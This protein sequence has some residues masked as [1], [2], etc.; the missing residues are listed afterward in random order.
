MFPSGTR[1]RLL[2]LGHRHKP[3]SRMIM[4]IGVSTGNPLQQ[5]T[6]LAV[7]FGWQGVALPEALGSLLE[8]DDW[9]G[10][11]R[12]TALLYPRGAVA[13]RRVLLVGL[14][15]ADGDVLDCIADAAAV[16]ARRAREIGVERYAMALPSAEQHDVDAVAQALTEG[17]I[18]GLYRFV[19]H[20]SIKTALEQRDIAEATIVV[21]HDEDAV[22][23]GVEAGSAIAAGTLLARDL[24]NA[25]GN[26]LPPAKLG[27]AAEELGAQYPIDVTVLGLS[28]LTAQGFGG[29]LAVGQGSANEPCFIVMEYGREHAS[30][31][32]ICLVGKGI[33]F[34]SGGISIKPAEN[35][36]R[37]KDDMSGA[38]AVLGTMRALGQRKLPIHVVGLISSAENMPSST[39]YRPGD[40]VTT[41][42]GIT[43]EVLNT[44]AE[45]RIVL[46]DALYYAQRYK[47]AAIIDLATLTGAIG[48]ALGPFASGLMSNNDDVAERLTQAGDAT[49]ERLWR[50]PLWQPYKDVVKSDFADI[51]NTGGRAGGALTAAAFLSFF[52]GEYPWAH[53]DIAATAWNEPS[54]LAKSYHARGATGVGVRLLMA[55]L[56]AWATDR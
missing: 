2:K 34:D 25:P 20:K 8:A 40:I 47:P 37:M 21:E 52:V 10:A 43:V 27:E 26:L 19:G 28:E 24:A 9:K 51:K 54:K 36:D 46:A 11:A 39:S 33:T 48:V 44:D 38:A 50:M 14:G 55:A 22:R 35:M 17:S 53:L 18:L 56:S 5:D 6:P 13:P 1:H 30:N 23:A 41:L 15:P 29:I 31:G 16:A 32:T 7:W 49:G 42:S 4:Q 45:G 3:E 12:Q